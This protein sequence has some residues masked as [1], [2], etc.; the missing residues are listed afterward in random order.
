MKIFKHSIFVTALL[1]LSALSCDKAEDIVSMPD[2]AETVTYSVAIDQ[3]TKALGEG[4]NVNY[5]WCGAYKEDNNNGSLTYTLS[6][7]SLTKVTGSSTHCKIEMVRDQ[8]Y[9]VVFVGQYFN[10]SN[11]E[12]TPAYR[13]DEERA[14][15]Y[16][17][18]DAVA[19]TDQYDLFTYVDPVT[20]FKPR[21]AK[22]ITLSRRVAQINFVA[23]PSDLA[24]AK[25]N[26]TAP[27][28]SKVVLSSVP[29][30]ISLLDGTVSDT[31]VQ[32][33]YA[34]A[35]LANPGENP[36]ATVFCLAKDSAYDV[37]AS[38]YLYKDGSELK[39]YTSI[40][41]PFKL[42]YKTNVTVSL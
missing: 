26:G 18:T 8:S 6:S 20:D 14:K 22:D 16:M 24:A 13:I 27:E 35:L 19:N 32:V 34:E 5:I 33:E 30:Y 31:S 4:N 2:Q 17:P 39:R 41:I 10:D 11:S 37:E 42:N 15:I 12:P 7:E 38:L 40:T 28:T 1:A 21:A 23:D 36:L 25:V 9:K 3:Q 29:E